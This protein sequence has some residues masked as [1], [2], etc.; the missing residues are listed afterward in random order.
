MIAAPQVLVQENGET[1]NLLRELAFSDV[2]SA[3]GSE[4]YLGGVDLPELLGFAV[5]HGLSP[6]TAIRLVTGDAAKLLGV[7]DRLGTLAPGKDADLVLLSAPPF[8]SGAGVR[9]VFVGGKEVVDESR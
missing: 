3:L 6:A 7:D 5:R 1:V 4:S 2:P 9:N 8:T